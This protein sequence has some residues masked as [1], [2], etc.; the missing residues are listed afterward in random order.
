MLE[1]ELGPDELDVGLAHEVV[2]RAEVHGVH[3][4]VVAV[5]VHSAAVVERGGV[6][7]DDE[8]VV[9]EVGD[10]LAGGEAL[11]EED[12]EGVWPR[13]RLVHRRDDHRP[14][15]GCHLGQKLS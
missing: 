6:D 10:L 12:E 14:V 15:V 11:A 1:G 7:G 4:E 2:G 3:L 9:E 13:E 8:D 5:R